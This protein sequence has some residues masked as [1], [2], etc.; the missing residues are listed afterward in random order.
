MVQVSAEL[1]NYKHRIGADRSAPLAFLVHGR[2]GNID[3][4]SI[5]Q[6]QLPAAWNFVQPQAPLADSI[7]GW[8][9]WD[10]SI[11]RQAQAAFI[12]EQSNN[13][14][15]WINAVTTHHQLAPEFLVAIGFSQGAGLLSRVMLNNPAL[16]SGVALLSG[17][18]VCNG[19]SFEPT[20]NSKLQATQFRSSVFVAHGT[21]DQTIPVA[22]AESGILYL[23][24][25]GFTVTTAL[26]RTGHKI[27]TS[28]MKALKHWLE[29]LGPPPGTQN[30]Q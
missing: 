13:F 17:F 9:W 7:G 30:S 23:R 3:V 19:E 2:A 25:R 1:Y 24:E 15:A 26:D 12:A 22:K 27:G 20:G 29:T 16:F 5:F 10:I 8:S 18:V 28:G 21:E 4:M 14:A 11:E 6:R